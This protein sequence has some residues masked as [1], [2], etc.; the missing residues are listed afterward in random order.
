MS[1]EPQNPT[2]LAKQL[3]RRLG[4]DLVGVTSVDDL[5]ES[6]RRLAQAV[7]KGCTAGMTYLARD[8]ARRASPRAFKPWARSI[9]TAGINYHALPLSPTNSGPRPLISRYALARDYHL[10]LKEKLR[11]L[12]AELAECLGRPFRSFSSVDTSPMMEKP[13]AARAGLGWQ[14]KNSL[15]INDKFGSWIFLAELLTD[16]DL[17]PDSPAE[18]RCGSCR[19]CIDAC[20][21]GALSEPGQ[22]DARKCISY[23]TVEH[24]GDFTPADLEMFRSFKPTGGYLF[25]CDICQQVCPFNQ[26]T[27]LTH[28]R[29]FQPRPELLNLT[30]EQADGMDESQFKAF[31]SETAMQRLTYQ[32]FQRNLHALR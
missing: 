11:Q 12:T 20:P 5:P 15:V 7:E 1:A 4:F 23:L 10:A 8:P 21:T 22:L 29:Q 30:I 26:D 28:E 24:K 27:P 13:L 32:Q 9:I 18:N 25:G 19:A 2:A 6:A 16:L 14:G 31:T 3:A 17:T